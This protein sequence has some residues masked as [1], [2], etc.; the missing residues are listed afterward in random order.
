MR[1]GL[2]SSRRQICPRTTKIEDKLPHAEEG[3]GS[4]SLLAFAVACALTLTACG[5]G[6]GSSTVTSVAITPTTA[7]VAINDTTEFVATVNLTNS[8][9]YDQHEHRCH[10]GSKRSGGRKHG[11][12]NDYFFDHRR[13]GWNLHRSRSRAEH[14]QREVNITAVAPQNPNSTSSTTTSTTVTSNTAV[15]TIGSGNGLAITEQTTTPVPAGSPRTFAATLN[16]LN[17]PNATWS[18]SSANGGNVGTIDA[19]SG[20]YAAP[21]FP[22]PGGTVTITAT[23]PT[24]A[25]PA[26]ATVEIVYSNH[27]LDGPF[28]FSYSGNDSDGFIAAAGSFVADGGGNITSGIEDT[29]SFLVGVSTGVH[30]PA[31]TW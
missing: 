3:Y 7:T 17:D 14:Q 23:D 2:S 20:Q 19:L 30:S 15:V 13:A 18:V 25:T 31:R 5:G 28:A 9:S 22:P 21:E 27:S 1:C 8:T 26:T 6:S 12:R 24:V 10:L 11:N 4:R 16:G 29:D